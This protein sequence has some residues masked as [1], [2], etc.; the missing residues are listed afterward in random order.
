MKVVLHGLKKLG[1]M[2]EDIIQIRDPKFEEL[3][4]E[5]KNLGVK[6]F[7]NTQQ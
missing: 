4:K 1:F 3:K 5:V 7:M 6:V 2:K